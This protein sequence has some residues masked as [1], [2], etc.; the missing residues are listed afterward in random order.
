MIKETKNIKPVTPRLPSFESFN[1]GN[2]GNLGSYSG[3]GTK[4]NAPFL[5]LDRLPT[6]HSYMSG[7]G[8]IAY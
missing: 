1:I 3:I 6:F 7:A 5:S 2:D 4:G 8:S